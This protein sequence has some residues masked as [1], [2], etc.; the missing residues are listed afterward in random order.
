[1]SENSLNLNQADIDAGSTEGTE[2]IDVMPSD[3][4]AITTE[5]TKE[6]EIV[7]FGSQE[8]SISDKYD[9]KPSTEAKKDEI[10][11][12]EVKKEE[13]PV[14]EPK[15]ETNS[16]EEV[17]KDEKS[18]TESKKPEEQTFTVKIN[19]KEEE[20]S[21]QELKNGFSG[22]KEVAR[23]F[24]ELDNE[25]KEWQNE[26]S[27]V[28]GWIK[29]VGTLFANNDTFKGISYI[30][31]L[32]GIPGYVL[33]EQLITAVTPEIQARMSMTN[34]ELRNQQLRSEN[35]YIQ[36]KNESE[37]QRREAEQARQAEQSAEQELQANIQSVQE[38]HNISE[39]EWEK[40]Y[41]RLDEEL[42]KDA[43][44]TVEMVRDAV[45]ETRKSK[46][47]V[48]TVESLVLNLSEEDRSIVNQ[49]WKD[50]LLDL[51]SR[52]PSLN[53]EDISIIISDSI[54]TYKKTKIEEK[55][56]SKGVERIDKQTPAKKKKVEI[57]QIGFGAGQD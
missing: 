30:A 34:E 41:N 10:V 19:G 37:R 26:K 36:S 9:T 57:P 13:K 11:P 27:T 29:D 45:L 48:E 20:V 1:M 44:L 7:G 52:N 21:L 39:E 33:K 3:N 8:E 28:E 51:M 24:K 18:P 23:R 50:E 22:A 14:E 12:D 42:P 31:D 49:S 4:E 43:D 15:K 47:Q 5:P 56:N 38:T 54:E 2:K 17:K 32:A 55:L 53:K 35:E 16:S 40:V 46:E 6:V 25:R